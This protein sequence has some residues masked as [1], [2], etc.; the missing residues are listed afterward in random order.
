MR[1]YV[2][3]GEEVAWYFPNVGMSLGWFRIRFAFTSLHVR[4][5][6][7]DFSMIVLFW[8]PLSVEA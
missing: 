3:I 2:Q 1:A 7:V 4:H 5:E 8:S 6:K